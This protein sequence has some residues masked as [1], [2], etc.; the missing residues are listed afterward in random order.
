M[1]LETAPFEMLTELFVVAMAKRA[2]VA[3]SASSGIGKTIAAEAFARNHPQQVVHY[4]A[5]KDVS[6]CLALQ[7]LL[8]AALPVGMQ[9]GKTVTKRSSRLRDLCRYIESTRGD[10]QSF[11]VIIDNVQLMKPTAL[12]SLVDDVISA[13]KYLRVG[14]VL[15]GDEHLLLPSN[16]HIAAKP[17]LMKRLDVVSD[18][19]ILG[20]TLTG[21]SFTEE[22][23]RSIAVACGAT[24]VEAGNLCAL[25]TA[26]RIE[27]SFPDV[28]RHLKRSRQADRR[29]REAAKQPM[30]AAPL[31]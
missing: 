30:M 3:V 17:S 5:R 16:Q 23:I 4:S 22:D 18:R 19:I 6:T 2:R 15:L 31:C 10:S 14:L 21:R 24:S 9:A 11:L 28:R 20:P 27:G 13:N 1:I 26:G 7:T 25:H 12:I 8:T 29:Q